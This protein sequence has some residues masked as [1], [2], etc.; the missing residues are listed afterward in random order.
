MP[1]QDHYFHSTRPMSS[2]RIWCPRY[3]PDAAAASRMHCGRPIDWETEVLPGD[4]NDK[5]LDLKE[6][7]KRQ[8]SCAGRK[9]PDK[10]GK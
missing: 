1:Q 4:A 7:L 3:T 2:G 5:Q 10:V 9:G 6:R 8:P